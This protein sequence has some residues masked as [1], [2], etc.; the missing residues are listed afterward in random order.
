MKT[1]KQTKI[2]RLFCVTCDERAP[3]PARVRSATERFKQEHNGHKT[4]YREGYSIRGEVVSKSRSKTTKS[5][6][7]KK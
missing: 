3:F 2:K 7:A 5:R 1:Q 6:K 4:I